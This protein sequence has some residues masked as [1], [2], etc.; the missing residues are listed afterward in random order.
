MGKKFTSFN[1]NLEGLD[2]KPQWYT[3]VTQYNYEQYVVNSLNKIIEENSN[4]QF[5]FEAFSGVVEREELY[6]NKKG[7]TK[8]KIRNEK[9][10]PNYVF[11]KAIMNV[12]AWNV[13][14][15]LTG[16]SAILCTS[17][18]PVATTDSKIIEIK[19]WLG[20]TKTIGE[21]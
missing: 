7:E 15:N 13:L 2:S 6:K 1:V 17:G 10:I 19:Q 14:T 9:I 4:E 16:V 21:I 8:T 18:T 20:N 11:V 3:I 12:R 5:V